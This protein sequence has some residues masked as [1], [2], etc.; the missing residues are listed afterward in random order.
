MNCI[1]VLIFVFRI[2]I[3]IFSLFP[4][5]EDIPNISF[6]NVTYLRILLAV[7]A[8]V[9]LGLVIYADKAEKP[10]AYIPFLF[11]VVS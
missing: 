2:I 4:R 5:N 6:V 10:W 11:V 7:S 8:L 9:I 3:Q 1:N